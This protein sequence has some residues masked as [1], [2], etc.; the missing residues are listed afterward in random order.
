MVP[1]KCLKERPY[2]EFCSEWGTSDVFY[3]FI[4]RKISRML[5]PFFQFIQFVLAVEGEFELLLAAL[6]GKSKKE[7]SVIE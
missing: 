2:Q 4:A 6:G 5:F 3:S 7:M 1:V